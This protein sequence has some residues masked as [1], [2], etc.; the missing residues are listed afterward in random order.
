MEL[1]ARVQ[2]ASIN[3]LEQRTTKLCP[4]EWKSIRWWSK[5]NDDVKW[6]DNVS[7]EAENIQVYIG[8]KFLVKETKNIKVVTRI[9][10]H[11]VL[12]NDE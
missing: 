3:V 2:M 8:T 7:I 1:S 11:F 12:L 9:W 10:F 6:E 5:D 4:G